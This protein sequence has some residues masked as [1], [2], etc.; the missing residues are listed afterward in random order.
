MASSDRGC[1]QNTVTILAT[2]ELAMHGRARGRGQCYCK[3]PKKEPDSH[4]HLAR[5]LEDLRRGVA[6]HLRLVSTTFLK[7]FQDCKGQAETAWD[8]ECSDS[9]GFLF[10][11]IWT[12]SKIKT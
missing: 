3:C 11:W 2:I 6:Q 9:L 8:I 12:D 4:A 5:R 10:C 1:G 7:K